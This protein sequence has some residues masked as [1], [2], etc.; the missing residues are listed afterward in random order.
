MH[1]SSPIILN[2]LAGLA[3]T[4]WTDV[5][6]NDPNVVC[7]AKHALGNY[8][9]CCS[10]STCADKGWEQPCGGDLN[11]TCTPYQLRGPGPGDGFY[12][13]TVSVGTC[14][15][16]GCS[17][18]QFN[19]TWSCCDPPVRGNYIPYQV[20]NPEYKYCPSPPFFVGCTEPN[21]ILTTDE[22]SCVNTTCPTLSI[23]TS[24]VLTGFQPV[25]SS[26]FAPHVSS[27]ATCASKLGSNAKLS[28][29]SS[30]RCAPDA[31]IE[32]LRTAGF[33][34]H[35]VGMA[36]DATLVLP[37]GSAC[38][39]TCMAQGYCAFN[40]GVSTCKNSTTCV[41]CQ[42]QPKSQRNTWVNNFFSCAKNISGLQVG[43][44]FNPALWTV[45]YS[46]FLS[47]EVML[48]Y[49]STLSGPLQTLQ[50]HYRSS[51]HN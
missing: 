38:N 39:K 18:D 3:S 29:T 28:V 49:D 34:P 2:L 6:N 44:T 47:Y 35:Q 24:S 32:S 46:H 33:S 14:P 19:Y 4:K 50:L 15:P 27:L 5:Y 17:Q 21:E 13:S 31:S 8:A 41:A 43:A 30:S 40:Q 25:V 16:N 23:P 1:L 7:H 37:D 12:T 36:L 9:C 42:G 26:T 10:D 11:S 20:N 45:G 22:E 51:R 48:T